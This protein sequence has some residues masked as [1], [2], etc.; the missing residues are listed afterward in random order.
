MNHHFWGDI[1]NWFITKIAGLRIN[2]KGNDASYVDIVPDF[3]TGLDH[4]SAYYD[5]V[6]GKVSVSWKRCGDEIHL[7]VTKPEDVKGRVLLKNGWYCHNLDYGMFCCHEESQ[8][9]VAVFDHKNN[10]TYIIKKK[11]NS[12]YLKGNTI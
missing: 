10:T 1:S 9:G 4:A 3:I 8:R 5:T 6:K 2:P 7:T 12:P 11:T